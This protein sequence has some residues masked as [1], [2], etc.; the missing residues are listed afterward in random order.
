MSKILS[1]LP[2]DEKVGIAFSGGLDTTC[3]IAWMKEKGADPCAYTADLGQPDED[4][5]D[6][7]SKRALEVGASIARLVDCKDQLADHAIIAIQNR[8]FHLSTAGKTY[9]NTTPLGRLVTGTM[10]VEEMKKDDVNIWGDGSTYKGNDIERYYRYGLM[11]NPSLKVYK[12]WLDPAFV[13]ELG[14][15]QEMSDWLNAH[16]IEYHMSAEKAYSSDNNMLGGTHEAKD[17]EYLSTSQK[18]LNPVLGV[19]HWLPEVDI[20]T[21]E[22]SVTFENGRPTKINDKAISNS[23]QAI[24]AANEIGGRHGLGMSDQIENRIIDAKSRGMYEA[25]GMA[26]LHIAYERLMTAI[27]NEDVLETYYANGYKLGLLL[28]K[29]QWF[30]PQAQ[31][32]RSGVAQKIA[33][34]VSGTVIVELRRG[35]DYTI[36]DTQSENATYSPDDLSMEVVTDASFTQLD[37]IG[38]LTM[39]NI[40]ISDTT[41]Y[42]KSIG[43]NP[44]DEKP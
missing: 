38:Q 43:E 30:D 31:M 36:L 39:K 26:L 13:A 24:F 3:A 35:D 17:I 6:D 10:L 1:S 4:H 32:L 19:K 23:V 29:G 7:I 44:L 15:R 18:I 12:P 37:R 28:Y 25:P 27:F 34:L 22:V 33:P 20:A 42:I 8:A 5:I 16:G 40:S 2:V 11:T 41:E 21:E 14:G 9:F